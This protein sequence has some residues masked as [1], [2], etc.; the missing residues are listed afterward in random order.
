[1]PDL[2]GAD[3][4]VIPLII[5][6]TDSQ[7]RLNPLAKNKVTIHIEGDAKIL[8]VDNGDLSDHE[9]Y[10]SDAIEV[11]EGKAL[12][13]IKTGSRLKD[14]II[15]ASAKGLKSDSFLLERK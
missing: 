3:A 10:Q 13:W 14:I 11:R 15:T 7:Q 8:G 9:P 1:M 5:S 4:D 12:V 6:V 2:A